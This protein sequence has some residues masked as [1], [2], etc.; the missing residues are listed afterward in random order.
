[1]EELT[2]GPGNPSGDGPGV[3]LVMARSPELTT[4]RAV[5]VVSRSRYGS[6]EEH[7]KGEGR[8]IGEEAA[9]RL[10]PS[11]ALHELSGAD[12]GLNVS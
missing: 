10:Y 5:M 4:D 12:P 6:V 3:R 9:E 1:M 7:G 11:V 8:R 2:G